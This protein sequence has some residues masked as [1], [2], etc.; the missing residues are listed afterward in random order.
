MHRQPR[1]SLP[2]CWLL[3]PALHEAHAAVFSSVRGGGAILRYFARRGLHAAPMGVIFD[4]RYHPIG[5]AVGEM[6]P[7]NG[8]FYRIFTEFRDTN[9]SHRRILCTMLTQFP[10]TVKIFPGSR[11]K[12]WGDSIEG[13]QSYGGLNLLP[14]FQHPEQQ[15]CQTSLPRVLMHD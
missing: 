7:K 3:P 13:C 12:I 10:G 11:V 15:C 8:K 4:A 2:I 9:D 14:D 5:A 1:D 6:G